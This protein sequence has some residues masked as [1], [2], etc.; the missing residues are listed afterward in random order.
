MFVSIYYKPS[1]FN[2][3]TM[4]LIVHIFMNVNKFCLNQMNNILYGN[5]S[6]SKRQG[7]SAVIR[8]GVFQLHSCDSTLWRNKK[9]TKT[10]FKWVYVSVIYICRHRH[11]QVRWSNLTYYVTLHYLQPQTISGIVIYYHHHHHYFQ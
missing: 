6:M 9:N 7:L 10:R 4:I 2:A 3:H 8:V 5:Q 1:L 11:W